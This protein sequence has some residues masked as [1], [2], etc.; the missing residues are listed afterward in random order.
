MD[1][2]WLAGMDGTDSHAKPFA[3]MC[4]FGKIKRKA[5]QSEKNHRQTVHDAKTN[6]SRNMQG[7]EWKSL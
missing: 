7:W 2:Y 4:A 1:M 5:K 6:W 3:Q